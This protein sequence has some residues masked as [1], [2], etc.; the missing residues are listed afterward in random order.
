MKF[1][2]GAYVV[3]VGV[4]DRA[5]LEK[6]V[7]DRFAQGD[8]FALA[9]LNLDHLVKLRTDADFRSAYAAQDFIVADG[10]PIVWM[11]R[12]AQQPVTL[13]PG[14]DLVLP[15]TQLCATHNVP[16]ALLGS[17]QDSLNRAAKVLQAKVPGL[18]IAC[19]IA[20][21]FGFD[22][23]GPEADRILAQLAASGARLCFL[24]LGAPKQELL[25]A[26]GRE[27]TPQIGFASIGAGLDFLS[28]SQTRAPRW[29]R[30]LALEWLWR[31][32]SSPRRMVG[33]YG[34][35]FTILP[36]HMLRALKARWA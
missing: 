4:P 16:V 25:A 10:N 26:R 5:A 36:G 6:R 15:L 9:T 30:R 19:C 3:K 14:S 1:H 24:A 33:R 8:G 32:L 18:S 12:L 35:S 20:P 23:Q 28:G 31:M 2:V 17:T 29:V 11:S 21:P 7:L 13:M 34:K 27:L 22:P